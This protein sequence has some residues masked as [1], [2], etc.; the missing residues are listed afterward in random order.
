[1][2]ILKKLFDIVVIKVMLFSWKIKL[3]LIQVCRLKVNFIFF[4]PCQHL[5]STVAY[6]FQFSRSTAA[7][8]HFKHN[9]HSVKIHYV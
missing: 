1:M 8:L 9:W 5:T 2:L 4:S 7:P 3:T 6:L